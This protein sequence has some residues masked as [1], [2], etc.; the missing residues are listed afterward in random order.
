MRAWHLSLFV[1]SA[2][3][4]A[5]AAAQ[6]QGLVVRDGT[7]GEGPLE[8][9]SGID[10][11][12]AAASYLITPELGAQRGSNLFHSFALF[13]IGHG[14]T[15]TFTG[16]N[17]VDNVVSRVTGGE[18]SEIHGTLRSTIPGADL[19]L[20]N[21]NGVVFGQGAELDVPGSFHASTGDY[22]GFEGGLERFHADRDP[23]RPSVLST[24]RPDAFGFLGEN[25]GA[26][27]S[28]PGNESLSVRSGGALAVT[29]NDVS[30]SHV[31]L[32]TPHGHVSL[33]AHDEVAL[34]DSRVDVSGKTPGSVSIRGGR[35]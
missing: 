35:L 21:P 31:A 8:V 26:S 29:G 4:A 23:S 1:A 9:G 34:T 2:L 12:G 20:L 22:L 19:W 16:P 25:G 30:L 13:G 32:T 17:S 6:N 14:E 28:M 7:L 27:I 18:L 10:P 15:A 24:A 5:S 33:E 11:T 3:A